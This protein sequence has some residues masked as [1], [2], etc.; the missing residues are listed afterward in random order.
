M[1]R[2]TRLTCPVGGSTRSIRHTK[3]VK[4]HSTVIYFE[5]DNLGQ[6]YKG[7]CIQR[8]R[9]TSKLQDQSWLWREAN[10]LDQDN[11]QLKLFT[12]GNNRRNPP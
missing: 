6:V 1:P 7:L 3:E 10:L 11:H 2:F 12:A 8:I 9:L 4:E 5:V